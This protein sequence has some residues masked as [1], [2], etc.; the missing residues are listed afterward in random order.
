MLPACHGA[1][2]GGFEPGMARPGGGSGSLNNVPCRV[3]AAQEVV[4][5]G[6]KARHIVRRL[7]AAGTA[8][9]PHRSGKGPVLDAADLHGMGP[10]FHL[11]R[12]QGVELP[13]RVVGPAVGKGAGDDHWLQLSGERL[14]PEGK[15]HV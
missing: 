8:V 3:T 1:A 5:A 2:N 14:D 4:L 10:A 15:V 13:R 7:E 9:V 6:A 12:A 11:M